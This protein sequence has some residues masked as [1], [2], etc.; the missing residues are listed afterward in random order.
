LGK[1][2]LK[3]YDLLVLDVMLPGMDI[4]RVENRHSCPDLDRAGE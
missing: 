3:R 2:A 4:T 1:A